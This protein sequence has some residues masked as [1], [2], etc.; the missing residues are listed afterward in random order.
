MLSGKNKIVTV[1]RSVSARQRVYGRARLDARD[2][3]QWTERDETSLI[4]DEFERLQSIVK[5]RRMQKELHSSTGNGLPALAQTVQRIRRVILRA[6]LLA[7]LPVF[8]VE[9]L[10]EVADFQFVEYHGVRAVEMLLLATA[11]LGHRA[12]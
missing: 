5:Q 7:S 1:R 12:S 2:V 8:Q 4:R 6:I 3:G 10:D 11:A 9:V